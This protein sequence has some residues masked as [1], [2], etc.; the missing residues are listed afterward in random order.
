MFL[1]NLAVQQQR[2]ARGEAKASKP[3]GAAGPAS[4]SV[5]ANKPVAPHSNDGP[6]EESAFSFL[7]LGEA[8]G[9]AEGSKY[10]EGMMK[11]RMKAGEQPILYTSDKNVTEK[12]L[13]AFFRNCSIMLMD[14]ENIKIIVDESEASKVPL[15]ITSM[16]YQKDVGNMMR[17][18]LEMK[19]T[20]L[21]V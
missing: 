19:C 14:F 3:K 6:V 13:L 20:F 2:K 12:V 1:N 7:A 21:V 4:S 8:L 18:L 17:L 10:E 16:E 9:E 15:F 11:K 5:T